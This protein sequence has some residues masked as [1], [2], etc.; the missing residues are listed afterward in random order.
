M[1]IAN[2]AV[3][4]LATLF[5]SFVNRSVRGL[6]MCSLGMAVLCVSLIMSLLRQSLSAT[7][8]ILLS[9]ILT[10]AGALLV[11][12]SL[13]LFR[14]WRP[15]PAWALTAF[16][17]AFLLPYCWFLF[18]HDDLQIRVAIVSP[19]NACVTLIGADTLLRQVEPR[20]R[21][22]YW[23]GAIA[24]LAHAL[25]MLGRTLI[26]ATGHYG[27]NLFASTGV[28]IA[29][30]V[31]LNLAVIACYLTVVS[32]SN[33]KLRRAAEE[34][35]LYDPLTHLPNHR[36][37]L[38]RLLE[39]EHHAIQSG[40]QLAIVYLDLDGFKKVNDTLGHQAGDETLIG[41]ARSVTEVLGRGGFLARVGGDEFVVLMEGVESRAQI[42]ALT[43]RLRNVIAPDA[44]FGVST[45][46]A[47]FPEDGMSAEAV[48]QHA[49]AAMYEAKRQN[50][51]RLAI[52]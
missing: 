24:M 11:S 34:M 6:R 13:R 32:A 35:A 5:T 19:F 12:Q 41:F 30:M 47:I 51:L 3:V 45:G 21:I 25:S 15:L 33:M 8:F 9:N 1:S 42:E 22:I 36:M 29:C 23:P 20:D 10:F 18:F 48:V 26:A 40:A 44:L 43:A 7:W 52:G 28:E 31:T 39:A 38:D 49:D 17:A 2:L 4:T 50:A 37:F 27:E 46:F 14:G 16:A